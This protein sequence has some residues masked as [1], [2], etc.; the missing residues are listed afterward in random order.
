MLK[1]RQYILQ[2]AAPAVLC[3][4][5]LAAPALANQPPPR[6]SHL[7][8]IA[9]IDGVL[10]EAHWAQATKFDLAYET[11]PSENTPAPVKT[12]AYLY[13]NGETLFVAF[14]ARD[15]EPAKIRAY[16]RDRDE[17]YSDDFVA[18]V[19]DTFNDKR[20]AVEFFVNARGVQM[21]LTVDSVINENDAWDAIWDSEGKITDTG[22]VVEMAI[23]L[24]ALRF[25]DAEGDKTWG[26]DLLRIWP[27]DK[28][29]RLSYAPRD[30][31]QSCYL[32]SLPEMQGLAETKPG[33]N[34]EIVPG[35]V[36][37]RTDVRSPKPIGDGRWNNGE[38]DHEASLD[39]RWGYSANG[40]LNLTVNPDFSQVESDVLE[41]DAT[42]TFALFY[43]EQR[44]FFLEG[45]EYFNTP[46]NVVHTRNINDPD[47]GAKVTGRIDEHTYGIFAADDTRT[48]VLLPA[49]FGSSTA[50]LPGES[51]NFAVRYRYD[52]SKAFSAGFLSTGRKGVNYRN[53]LLGFDS[54][55]Q[56]SDSDTIDAQFLHS[57][58]DN[59]VQLQA[60]GYAAQ[61]QGYAY[62][63]NYNHRSRNWVGHVRDLS[64]DKEFRADMG[65]I[66]QAYFRKI[67]AGL[68]RNF[69]GQ[70]GATFNRVLWRGNWERT[71][72]QSGRELEDEFES[73]LELNGPKQ[74]Q[75]T[76]GGGARDRL[77][78]N[79][80]YRENY[81]FMSGQI[82][83]VGSF[84]AALDAQFG[85]QI[86]FAN[87]G[88][89]QLRA[90]SPWISWNMTENFSVVAQYSWNNLRVPG[91]LLRRT[92]ASDARFTWQFSNRSFVRLTLQGGD[93]LSNP[94]RYTRPVDRRTRDLRAQLLYSYK[95]N[96]QTVLYAGVSQGAIDNDQLSKLESVDRSLFLKLSYAWMQ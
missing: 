36:L 27:R 69:W 13:E 72:N 29:Y 79:V 18:I 83:P 43:P 87:G 56:L 5:M 48:D 30:R 84:R 8:Q 16:L 12:T 62:F 17:A 25:S 61:Q 73:A 33:K 55:I 4:T 96:P 59:P 78:R 15:P 26:V 11:S 31:N 23:P 1:T 88:L 58:T 70:R 46:L 28:R 91:G 19:L 9:V 54:R 66:P 68:G 93:T 39:M 53:V 65:F 63:L 34:L 86:D 50:S 75:L 6:I 64:L 32:C 14:D 82:Q 3:T 89:G 35:L 74:L 21:D 90:L 20:R 60:R 38:L 40:S 2:A 94:L 45:A 80:V 57:D 67:S 22:Y 76:V 52:A 95:L 77:W 41:L 81:G 10:N 24:R 92:T 44:P 42:T 49:P 85:D 7:K 51:E 47:L 37:A 71:E